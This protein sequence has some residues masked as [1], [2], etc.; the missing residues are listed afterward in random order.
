[1]FF[2]L[3]IILPFFLQAL[4]IVNEVL[5]C[6]AK[7]IV[8]SVVKDCKMIVKIFWYAFLTITYPVTTKVLNGLYAYKIEVK[9]RE[10]AYKK[11]KGEDQDKEEVENLRKIEER[12]DVLVTEM[13]VSGTAEAIGESSL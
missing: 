8:N 1:M 7:S 2:S 4:L 11:T 5:T 12:Q 9:N 3:T 6:N 10:V 13:S